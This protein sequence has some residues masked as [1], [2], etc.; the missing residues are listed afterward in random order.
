[1]QTNRREFMMLGTAAV[2]ATTLA[3]TWSQAAARAE[4]WYSRVRRWGQ[5]NITENDAGNMDVGFWRKYW[6][7]TE[8]QGMI[9]N[10]GG[11]V[12]FYPTKIPYH[13]VPAS[14]G[15][16]DL[17]GEL[18]QAC[19]EDGVVLCAR[20]SY[21]YVNADVFKAHPD[22]FCVDAQGNRTRQACMNGGYIYE[23][24]PL[25]VKEIVANY[26]PAGFSLSAWG[27][28]YNLCYCDVCKKLFKE[29]AGH[30][31]PAAK[32][33]DHPVYR[34]WVVWNDGQVLA[35]WDFHNSVSKAAGGPDCI[36]VGQSG[37]TVIARSMK[38]IL[39]RTPMIMHDHQVRNDE[40]GFQQ[41][42]EAGKLT[43][44][45]L[46]WDKVVTECQATFAPRLGSK[47][48]PE[49]QMWMYEGM[50]GSITP[51]WHTIGAYSEDKRRFATAVPV[52]NWHK[53][54]E[55][56]LY[57]RTP[58]ATVGV[59]WSED[60]NIFYGRDDTPEKVLLPWRGM[61]NALVRARIPY[62]TVYADQ[63][64]RDAAQLSTLVLP[65]VAA[66]TDAQIA[67][68]KRFVD[69]GGGLL[70]TGESSLYDKFGDRRPDYALA[71]L[72][73]THWMDGGKTDSPAPL[74]GS[75]ELKGALAALGLTMADV[76]ATG[77]TAN[78]TYL[79]LTPELRRNVAGPHND[80]EPMVP[81]DAVRHPVLKGF[82]GTDL[83]FFG[84]TSDLFKTDAGVQVL[85]TYIPPSPV[86]PP[87]NDWMRV[88][89]TDT[90]ALIVNTRPGG[91]RVAFL[92]A[93]VDR[94]YARLN[95]P[96]HGNLLANLVRWTAKDNI[97]LTVQ[98]PGLLDCNLYQQSGRMVLHV[99]N[100]VSAATWRA[101]LDEFIA[102]GPV[103]V[104]VK[105]T[106]GVSGLRAKLLVSGEKAPVTVKDGWAEVKI[107]S[108]SSHEVV[109]IA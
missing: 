32:N 14:M 55:E 5:I 93:D 47:P 78:Q 59:V 67:S 40:S 97:P 104:R 25:I 36:W 89:K 52:F 51:W 83:I 38:G 18:A 91:G 62:I 82:D 75:S 11:A 90:P 86:L 80:T 2:A 101:P 13:R 73:G 4:P 44:G 23:Y 98:G 16:R 72:F 87:E 6:R 76:A 35:L 85:M 107:P 66:L 69:N 24:T 48:A 50:A 95:Y 15:N 39:A 105:L 46:G 28:N 21:G 8:V 88:P 53:A 33:W 12:A 60:N 84:G 22:W 61:I 37:G 96:D 65:N 54:N 94:Q 102:I 79:R 45:L 34:D 74:L 71:D 9:L 26:K 68:V 19:K 57:N 30:D 100:L 109:V 3:S 64:D 29:K 1:M 17:L 41:N 27:A 42:S 92:P 99:A 43:H 7:E 70:A 63:I 31:L 58:V 56:Y 103:T 20:L 106:S 77:V 10:A 108:I 81:P 49:A